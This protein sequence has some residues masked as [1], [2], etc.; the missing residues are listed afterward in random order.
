MI[1]LVIFFSLTEAP[2]PDPDPTQH[3]DTDPTRTRNGPETDRNGPEM[4][5]NQTLWGGTARGF[6]G[7]GG[8]VLREKKSLIFLE[9]K[10]AKSFVPVIFTPITI[11]LGEPVLVHEFLFPVC[12]FPCLSSLF[13]ISSGDFLAFL[14]RFF[15]S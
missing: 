4:D 2:L 14:E 6:V 1:F 7:M 15:P 13:R 3:P 12:D 10:P 11:F 5:R 8:G 9:E